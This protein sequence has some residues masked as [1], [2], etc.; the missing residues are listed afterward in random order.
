MANSWH[1]LA[2]SMSAI[3]TI[4][5]MARMMMLHAAIHWPDATD[6]TQWPMAVTHATYLYNHMPHLETG[7]S[8]VDLFTK[9]RWEQKKLHGFSFGAANSM[10][11]AALS[12]LAANL[13]KITDEP[14]PAIYPIAT[15]APDF[16]IPPSFAGISGIDPLPLDRPCSPV[17]DANGITFDEVGCLLEVPGDG[18]N[19]Q[20]VNNLVLLP[21]DSLFDLFRADDNETFQNGFDSTMVSD[22]RYFHSFINTASRREDFEKKKMWDGPSPAFHALPYSWAHRRQGSCKQTPLRGGGSINEDCC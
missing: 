16:A 9:M 11:L 21:N 17:G 15:L 3:G 1:H 12:L 13:P 20:G 19:L 10:S 6:A 8:P 7:I 4:T 14:T 18:D 5:N 2:E 22:R